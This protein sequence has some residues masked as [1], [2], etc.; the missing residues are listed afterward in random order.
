[1]FL[2][3]NKEKFEVCAFRDK[4]KVQLIM[5]LWHRNTKM[6]NDFVFFTMETL[7]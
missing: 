4:T 1:M 7:N 5:K 2:V 6:T 3:I